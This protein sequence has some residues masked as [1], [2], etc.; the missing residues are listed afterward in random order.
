[1][2]VLETNQEKFDFVEEFDTFLLDCDGVIW[3]GH[4]TISGVI[5]VLAKLRQMNK[6]LIFVTNNSSKS[7]FSYLEKFSKMGIDASAEEIFGSAYCAA[8]YI[9]NR[10]NLQGKRVYVVG[11]NGITEE[12]DS[13]DVP[14]CGAQQDNDNITDIALMG[15]V[16]MENDV[17]A[18]LFGLDVN[19]NYKKLAK[20][21]TH[22]Q[23]E[24]VHFLA[25]NSDLTF[26]VNGTVYPGTGA[27]LAALSAPLH[28]KP[29]VLGKPHQT[30]LDCI[31]DKNHLI[32]H[33]TCMIGDRLDTD[34]AFGKTGD[35]KT[36]LVLTGI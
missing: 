36:L 33:R 18:V 20:A 13:L 8:Y 17:K 30:M 21:F 14:W 10:V 15:Q 28:R 7:R 22:L 16:S 35:I 12:L 27:L 5:Q 29:I 25:T 23:D 26:P 11:M 9:K 1:M 2:K 3:Q 34:I 4:E 24:N 19:L 31:I 6:R 32:R